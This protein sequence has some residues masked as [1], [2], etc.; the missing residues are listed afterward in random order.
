MARVRLR[1][2]SVLVVDD[3]ASA[4]RATS[5][6][7]EVADGFQVEGSV[8]S[9][10]EAVAFLARRPVDLVLMDLSM[11]GMG[12]AA[13][14]LHIRNHHPDVVVVLLSVCPADQLPIPVRRPDIGFCG[15]D[16][17]GPDELEA[18]WAS[19]AHRR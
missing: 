9:G 6:V 16:R 7:V 10:E 3:L 8:G 12:G 2:V 5:A 13:A 11:P 17:F 1:P 4:R 14:S 15:K 18:Q 19:A